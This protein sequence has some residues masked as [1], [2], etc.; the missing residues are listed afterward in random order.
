MIA[1]ILGREGGR[2]EA[3]PHPNVWMRHEQPGGRETQTALTTDV[4]KPSMFIKAEPG[5]SSARSNRHFGFIRFHIFLL[6]HLFEFRDV[7]CVQWTSCR[8]NHFNWFKVQGIS[9]V[10]KGQFVVQPAV[11][12][13]INTK[14]TKD[15][16]ILNHWKAKG[17]R[18]KWVLDS[19]SLHL[20]RTFLRP[21]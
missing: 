10:P 16:I 12:A 20:G 2:G 13:D 7:Q 1:C 14:M 3:D 15:H 18:D 5:R 9:I 21:D 6:L 19:I 11:T 4:C 8:N 17:S